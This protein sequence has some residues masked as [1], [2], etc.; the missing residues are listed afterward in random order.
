MVS[1]WSVALLF[2]QTL[3][4]HFYPDDFAEK[5]VKGGSLSPISYISALLT[6]EVCVIIGVN[7]NYI[8]K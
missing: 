3:M 2:V 7:V 8:G 4:Q 5:C 6:L 1:L